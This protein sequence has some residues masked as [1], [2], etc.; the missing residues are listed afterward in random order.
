VHK[1]ERKKCTMSDLFAISVFSEHAHDLIDYNL[2]TR[3]S[4]KNISSSTPFFTC[5][6]PLI[7]SRVDASTTACLGRVHRQH[8]D[9]GDARGRDL[10]TL[11]K[12][13]PAHCLTTTQSRE[14]LPAIPLFTLLGVLRPIHDP[15]HKCKRS[16]HFQEASHILCPRCTANNATCAGRLTPPHDDPGLTRNLEQSGAAQAQEAA[17]AQQP[18]ERRRKRHGHV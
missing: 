15:R 14:S 16:Y 11:P 17:S 3:N 8:R 7:S 18:H 4:A 1:L 5:T 9:Q 12:A 2:C 10:L 13:S 6:A